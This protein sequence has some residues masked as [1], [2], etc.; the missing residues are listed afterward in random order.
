MGVINRCGVIAGPWQMG[1]VDQ[2]VVALWVAK[3]HFEQE[4][5]YIGYGGAGK[6]VRDVLHID[7]LLELVPV[8]NGST[9]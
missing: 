9:E 3:H 2:G 5:S 1:K 8:P 4:L 6:Q 7:D